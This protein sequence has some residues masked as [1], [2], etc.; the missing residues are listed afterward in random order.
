MS[1]RRS[2]DLD[3]IR[4][5]RR[6]GVILGVLAVVVII[7]VLSAGLGAGAALSQSCNLNTL[8]PVEIGQN[9][10]VFARDGSVLGSIPAERNR[11]PVSNRQMSKWLPRATVSIEDRRFYQHGGVDYEGIARAAWKDVT[12]GKVVEGGSTITQQLVR[13][14]YTGQQKTF[15]RKLREACLAIKLS[16]KQSKRQI[17]TEYLNTVYYGN[18]AYGVEA[19]S[20]TYFS[21]HASQLSLA[22]SALLAGLP[23]APSVYDPFH[24]PEA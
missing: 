2:D 10:F 3:F 7:G 16:R 8:R 23:Q 19:A 17:L 15:S 9:S 21:K 22:Q 5:R 1:P 12:A 4:R 14:L 6:A 24:N 11:E 20:Q 18:H 13:N